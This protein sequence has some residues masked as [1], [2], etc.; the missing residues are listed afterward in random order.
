MWL[1]DVRTYKLKSFFDSN[2]PPYAILSHTW[3]DDELTFHGVQNPESSTWPSFEKVRRT[4]QLAFENDLDYVWIDTC[5]IDK[6][7]SA[8][9][10]EAINSMFQWYQSATIC[11]ALLSDFE[12]TNSMAG[13]RTDDMNFLEGV[14]KLKKCRWFSRG[15]CL[16]ELIAPVVLQFYNEDWVFLSTKHDW[17]NLLSEVTGIPSSMLH[18]LPF[19]RYGRGYSNPPGSSMDFLRRALQEFSIAQRMSWAAKRQTSRLEDV[20]Y[21]L[22]GIFGINMT[23]LYGEGDNAFLRLQE[24]IIKRSTD[25]S[26]LAWDYSSL[27]TR[28]RLSALLAEHPHEFSL[29]NNVLARDPHPRHAFKTGFDLTNQGLRITFPI[30]HSPGDFDWGV[31][32]CTLTDDLSGPLA[33]CL[34]KTEETD[35]YETSGCEERPRMVALPREHTDTAIDTAIT[36]LPRSVWNDPL[37]Y[38]RITQ[39][40]E[41]PGG[42]R[43]NV[44]DCTKTAYVLETWPS[45]ACV[46]HHTQH[47]RYNYDTGAFET[48]L[49]DCPNITITLP[50][51]KHS[52]AARGVRIKLW[53]DQDDVWE[54][55]CDLVVYRSNLHSHLQYA[56][57]SV[58]HGIRSRSIA[59]S[60]LFDIC[61]DDISRLPRLEG[62]KLA[63]NVG[64]LSIEAS[65]VACGKRSRDHG[66]RDQFSQVDLRIPIQDPVSFCEAGRPT[67]RVEVTAIESGYMEHEL[68]DVVLMARTVVRQRNLRESGSPHAGPNSAADLGHGSKSRYPPRYLPE[69]FDNVEWMTFNF[70]KPE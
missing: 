35:V 36:M 9:L 56:I 3:G 1:I 51:F 65:I 26:I 23:L 14:A 48:T 11:Y 50:D 37:R 47:F 49:L 27:S 33:L 22:L 21:S 5:C 43:I 52:E 69:A 7:S 6:S 53:S 32:N 45:S 66:P 55:F 2:I 4:C 24:E 61:V 70:T 54:A 67:E 64:G 20:A 39:N 42:F 44:I 63:M 18:W 17:A 38:S 62:C 29:C 16:Q 19:W 8:E 25:H 57:P 60:S 10:S 28:S 41:A 40:P 58:S 46:R 31:L 59:A 68:R 13:I 34:W 30:V 15:W 12:G